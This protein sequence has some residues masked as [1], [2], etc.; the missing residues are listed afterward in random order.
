[1]AKFKLKKPKPLKRPKIQNPMKGVHRARAM[2]LTMIVG[3]I[4]FVMSFYLIYKQIAREGETISRF[5]GRGKSKSTQSGSKSGGGSSESAVVRDGGGEASGTLGGASDRRSGDDSGR[6]IATNDT[7]VSGDGG[8]RSDARGS[9]DGFSAAEEPF[10]ASD[11][12]KVDTEDPVCFW[13]N[14]GKD[15]FRSHNRLS[16]VTAK[17]YFKKAL[18][19]ADERSDPNCVNTAR[20]FLKTLERQG[21]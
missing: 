8:R 17:R 7:T 20:T 21:I 5:A 19:Y 2:F 9:S 14:K 16:I 10:V 13:C 6:A 4:A 18:D 11:Q 12:I 3:T 1:M 15:M